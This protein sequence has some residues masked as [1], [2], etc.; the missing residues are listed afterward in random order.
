MSFPPQAWKCTT[1][2]CPKGK[3]SSKKGCSTWEG[4]R[5]QNFNHNCFPT[6]Y[7]FLGVGPPPPP[8]PPPVDSSP[9]AQGSASAVAEPEGRTCGR[10]VFLFPLFWVERESNKVTFFESPST[11]LTFV[12]CLLPLPT[13]GFQIC[14]AQERERLFFSAKTSSE[15]LLKLFGCGSFI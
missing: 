13:A 6:A 4:V 3:Q 14:R 10:L 9:K 15:W 8:S 11:E 5:N 7:G 2:P 1:P 12:L